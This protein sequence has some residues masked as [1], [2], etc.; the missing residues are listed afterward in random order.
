MSG[1]DQVS[2]TVERATSLSFPS[3]AAEV[4]GLLEH[5]DPQVDPVVVPEVEVLEVELQDIQ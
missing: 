3:L 2:T 4:P 1:L 5:M